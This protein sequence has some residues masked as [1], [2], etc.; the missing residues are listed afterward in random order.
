MLAWGFGALSAPAAM[1]LA[2]L[3]WNR[4]LAGGVLAAM[5][6]AVQAG[7]QRRTALPTAAACRAAFGRRAS[8][9][10]LILTLI[11]LLLAAADAAKLSEG[12][13]ERGKGAEAAPAVLLALAALGSGKGTRACARAAGV[14]AL[15]LAVL[16]GVVLAGA[17]SMIRAPWLAPWGAAEQIPQSAA[18]L[19][20]PSALLYLQA[21][22]AERRLLRRGLT[23]LACGPAVLCAAV[24]G[25]LSPQV[26]AREPF[27]L[28][29][30]TKSV[31]LLSVMQRFE[32]L[33]SVGTMTGAYLL[34]TLLVCCAK[35]IVRLLAPRAENWAPGAFC[36]L[37]FFGG[38]VV[39][40]IPAAAWI[41][42]A[43]V[44][45]GFLPALTQWVV[46]RKK[47]GKNTKK[48]VDKS[49]SL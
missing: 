35:N 28:Y 2:G 13:F 23:A 40:R 39:D 38:E 16:F 42:G 43:A 22:G 15:L 37:A 41:T 31:S 33:L 25:G 8:D 18:L 26:A 29:T 20:A 27:A 34:L 4:V 9:L 7:L 1:S 45:W 32:A 6:L 11:W 36:V 17:A 10:L 47:D 30:L 49:V 24:S 12:I 5:L 14:W 44:F 3:A 46:V 21:A 19:L 48:G